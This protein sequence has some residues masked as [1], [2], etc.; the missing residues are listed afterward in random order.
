MKMHAMLACAAALALGA[1]GD[2]ANEAADTNLVA[3]EPLTDP[4]NDLIP[5]AANPIEYANL[6]AANDRFEI[7]SAERALATSENAEVQALARS[8]IADHRRS[9][10]LLRQAA[11]QAQP[12]VTTLLT[13]YTAEQ[14][15]KLDGLNGLSGTEFDRRFLIDQIAAHEEAYALVNDYAQEGEDAAMRQHASTVAGPI[16]Q[17]LA[18][19]RELAQAMGEGR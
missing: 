3:G 2:G 19:A 4:T 12:P 11:A 16:Q 14:Q 9:T 17:H 5:V 15:A 1:C 10:E 18:R 7:E 8:I 6:V 13:D